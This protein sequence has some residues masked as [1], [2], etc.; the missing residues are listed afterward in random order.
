M[1]V[2]EWV[3]YYNFGYHVLYPNSVAKLAKQN[4]ALELK[5][6]HT[7]LYIP[8]PKDGCIDWTCVCVS[9]LILGSS[10]HLSTVN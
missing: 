1:N 8:A 2:V 3:K 7:I 10:G 4:L 9:L 6:S 5:P